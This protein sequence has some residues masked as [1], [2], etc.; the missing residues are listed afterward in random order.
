MEIRTVVVEDNPEQCDY[1]ADL[2]R[3]SPA[4]ALDRAFTDPLKALPYVIQSGPDLLLLDQ[5]MPG[6]KGLDF[7]QEII[8][9]CRST[10]VI[11]L[12]GDASIAVES[13]SLFNV[14][15]FIEK[16][17]TA[18]K[19]SACVEKTQHIMGK[20]QPHKNYLD[21]GFLVHERRGGAYYPVKINYKDIL[22]IVSDKNY[23]DIHT[24]DKKH[25]TR[26][27]IADYASLLHRPEFLQ[28]RR[29]TIINAQHI[30]SHSRR[31][32]TMRDNHQVQISRQGY[33]PL[34]LEALDTLFARWEKI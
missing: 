25:T 27:T 20:A 33:G 7:A 17:V 21:D 8:D 26:R 29:G 28:A 14:I 32:I 2:V 6:K 23:C 24:I 13:I 1:V 18:R 34:F 15:H 30:K 4:L 9:L 16:P 19:F 3:E 10:Y 11:F 5:K 22:Y 12:T 31:S